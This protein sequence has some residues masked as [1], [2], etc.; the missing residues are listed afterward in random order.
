MAIKSGGTIPE[1]FEKH[2]RENWVDLSF[3]HKTT[4]SMGNLIPMGIK[5]VYPGELAKCRMEM[6]L[7]FA[8]LFL[9]IMHQVY[10]TVD[11]FYVR[12]GALYAK[13]PYQSF[14]AFIV[15]HP[16]TGTIEWAWMNLGSGAA[17]GGSQRCILNYMGF[18]SS[19][20]VIGPITNIAV[21]AIPAAAY[22]S[23]WTWMY[24]NPNI[25]PDATWL[26]LPGDNTAGLVAAMPSFTVLRRNWPRDYYTIATPEPQQ[27]ANVLIPSFTTDPETGLHVPQKL[28]E[29]DGSD[30]TAQ[31]LIIRPTTMTL[32]GADSTE[33]VLQLSSTIRDFR[34]AAQMTEF[35]ERATRAGASGTGMP[36]GGQPRWND[37]VKRYF[38]WNPNPLMIDMPVWIGGYTGNVMISDVM[39]TAESGTQKVGNYAGKAVARDNTPEFTY[40]IPDYGVIIP[41]VTI[42]P[43]ASYYVGP[44]TIWWRDHKLSYMWEQF[45][46]IG[47]QPMRNKEVWFSWHPADQTWNNEIFGYVPQY[48]QFRF[49]NDIV[50]GQMRTLWESFHLGRKFAAFGD[51]ILNS[52]FITCEPDVARVFD[53]DAENEEDECYVQAYVGINVLRKLPKFGLPEL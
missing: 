52:D 31:A 29:L 33:V 20:G 51:V 4:I 41:I 40:R 42:Y 17:E 11:W 13:S 6:Q 44:D 5:E 26:L 48:N 16:V 28:L 8:N 23:I 35:L 34:Y 53:V 18:Q 24:R 45:A 21:S 27:G 7:K 3:N 36:P 38:D 9:P 2:S 12:T 39:S 10:Y 25:Q 50:S 30:P 43:K 1:R 32:S 19:E 22:Y 46:L 47:D 14:E 37:F 15:Q 49:S